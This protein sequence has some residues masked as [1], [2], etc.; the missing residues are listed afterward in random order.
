MWLPTM[1]SVIRDL[2]AR[3]KADRR[4]APR[5]SAERASVVRRQY[6]AAVKLARVVHTTPEELLDYRRSD[7][8][9]AGRR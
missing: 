1:N 3:F 7:R 5:E 6:A 9:L 8:I 4:R 2:L